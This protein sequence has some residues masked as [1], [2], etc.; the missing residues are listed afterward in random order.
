M[1]FHLVSWATPGHW[2]GCWGCMRANLAATAARHV[3]PL[4]RRCE[5][6]QGQVLCHRSG[7]GGCGSH[8]AVSGGGA[9]GASLFAAARQCCALASRCRRPA[10][11]QE[12]PLAA[13][14]AKGRPA[15]LPRRVCRGVQAGCLLSQCQRLKVRNH[16]LNLRGGLEARMLRETITILM[17]HASAPCSDDGCLPVRAPACTHTLPCSLL[18]PPPF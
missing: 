13:I 3:G 15:E 18:R 2:R 16:K 4:H 8:A 1:H 9:G 12:G 10:G 7:G 14:A 6:L 17:H 11:R 5:G